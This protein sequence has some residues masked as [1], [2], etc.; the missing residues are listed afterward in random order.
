LVLR[1]A[2]DPASI[3]GSHRSTTCQG[4]GRGDDAMKRISTL[5]A[6]AGAGLLAATAAPAQAETQSFSISSTGTADNTLSFDQFDT[7]LGTLTGVTFALSNSAS[8]QDATI[9]LT[10][11]EGG[12][13][14]GTTV[15]NFVA[16]GPGSGG[17]DAITLFD[18]TGTTTAQCAGLGPGCSETDN[19]TVDAASFTTPTTVN[20]P[21]DLPSYEGTGTFDVGVGFGSLSSTTNLCSSLGRSVTPTCTTT[22]DA[23]WSGDITVTFDY[24]PAV[25]GV[26]EPGTFTLF[27][28][29]LSGLVMLARPRRATQR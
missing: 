22:G 12:G 6:M 18:G 27:A 10:G 1:T 20:G 29:A 4:Y 23:A 21:A 11:A 24:T 5:A 25:T 15:A 17:P 9:T 14:A 8:S 16:L 7:T 13:G 2:N 26:P 28:A 19:G 3:G